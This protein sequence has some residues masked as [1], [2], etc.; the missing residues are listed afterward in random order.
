MADWRLIS[1]Q[2]QKKLIQRMKK[3]LGLRHHPETNMEP[4]IVPAKNPNIIDPHHLFLGFSS[5]TFFRADRLG[6]R[7]ETGAVE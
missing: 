2:F 3:E 7:G 5:V 6:R 4:E 1:F